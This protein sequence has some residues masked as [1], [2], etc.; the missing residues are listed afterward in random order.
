MSYGYAGKLL[1]INLSNNEIHEESTEDLSAWIGGRG[2]GAYLLSQIPELKS[3]D[4]ARQPIAICTGPLV[5]TGVPLGTRTAVSARNLL[6]K[7]FCY[8]NVGGDFGTRMKMAGYDA[9][10]LEGKSDH[11][12]YLL[13]NE[14]GA[15]ILPAEAYWGSKITEFQQ[16]L[17]EKY[18]EKETSFLGI[19]PAGENGAGIS[20]LMADQAHAAG[21]GGSGALFGAKNLKAVV[22]CGM[23]HI[24]VFDEK[25]LKRKIK[26][27]EWRINASETAAALVR[28]GTHGTAGAG[29]HSRLVPTAVKNI[30]DEFLSAEESAPIREET[31]K[32][33][34]IGRAGCIGCSVRCLHLYDMDSQKHGKLEVEGMHANSV[35]G[36]ASNLGVDDAEDLLLAHKLCNEY[37]LDVDG[38]SAVAAFALECAEHGLLEINQPGGVRLAWG[39]GESMVKLIQQMGE[40]SGLG[41]LLSEGTQEAARQIGKDSEKYAMTVKGVGINEQGIRSHKAWSLGIMTSTRG[42]GHLG[43]APQTE[44]RRVSAEVGQRLFKNPEA[45][46]PESYNGKG[47]L[48]AWTEGVKAIV[49]SIGLCYFLYG[50]YDLTIGPIEELAEML[51]L[52]T[53][54]EISGEE[55]HKLGLR[56]HT[57][58]RYMTYLLGGYTRKDDT[59]PDRFFDSPVS[60]GPYTG[61]K[62]DREEVEKE[63][64]EYYTALG[65]DVKYGIPSDEKLVELGVSFSKLK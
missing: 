13:L 53:G 45:G 10:V 44:N 65:W 4:P 55:L 17:F 6:S 63:L 14:S 33:W 48:V 59:F 19:G 56:I 57:M 7:G 51:Y 23:K 26:Q 24:P 47:K 50:W 20:C 60:S 18:S 1:K 29:G 41:K 28:G 12:V 31:Y 9:I 25:G 21:W 8:S 3:E 43:G 2:L 58:E 52:A 40:R 61:A 37:G 49:D 22:A 46:I 32:Q 42:G 62:L 54:V 30:R 38:V 16:A 35:R 34:E 5:G 36:L 64:D 39:D 11:P 15:Q 27:L